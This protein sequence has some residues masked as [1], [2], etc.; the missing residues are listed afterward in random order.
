MTPRAQA[1]AHH[2]AQALSALIDHAD[3]TTAIR[4]LVAALEALGHPVVSASAAA[5]L[6]EEVRALRERMARRDAWVD[7]ALP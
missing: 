7:E 5:T 6:A 1:A 4:P 2:A 3:P